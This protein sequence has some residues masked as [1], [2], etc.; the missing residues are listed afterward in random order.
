LSVIE[1]NDNSLKEEIMK[2]SGE[3]FQSMEAYHQLGIIDSVRNSF[4][5]LDGYLQSQIRQYLPVVKRLYLN[6]KYFLIDAEME[7]ERAA[8]HIASLRKNHDELM[9]F[10]SI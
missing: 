5:V 10:A 3:I 2:S 7:K 1:E 8:D 4:I 6:I 9:Q